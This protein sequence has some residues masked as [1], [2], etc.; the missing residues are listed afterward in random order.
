MPAGRTSVDICFQ[1]PFAYLTP[2]PH[3]SL[4]ITLMPNNQPHDTIAQASKF[5][6]ENTA[7]IFKLWHKVA[8]RFEENHQNEI[9]NVAKVMSV[10][11]WVQGHVCVRASVHGPKQ[12]VYY[13]TDCDHIYFTR[14]HTFTHYP[15]HRSPKVCRRNFLYARSRRSTQRQQGCEVRRESLFTRTKH[16]RSPSSKTH[17]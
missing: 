11:G 12:I 1:T 9:G 2:G 5:E 3:Q 17:I 14:A 10:S 13:C 6:P 8:Q 4:H 15:T 16:A 7:A